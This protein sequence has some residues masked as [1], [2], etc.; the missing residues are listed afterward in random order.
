V[1]K[2]RSDLWLTPCPTCSPLRYSV[3]GTALDAKDIIW[4][5]GAQDMKVVFGA[6]E[7]FACLRDRLVL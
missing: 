4:Y 6:A 2:E 5:S 1:G 3:F 7:L